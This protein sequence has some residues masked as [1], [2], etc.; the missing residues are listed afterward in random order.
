MA[1]IGE[2]PAEETAR[3]RERSDLPRDRANDY[4]EQAARQRCAFLHHKTGAGFSHVSS[5][6]FEPECVRGNIEH[7]IGAAQVPIGV[8]GPLRI[9][10]EHAQGDF[11]IPLATTE[12][13]VV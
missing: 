11:Y 6:S 13:T 5:Y 12:G 3:S 1:A 7:F 8:A 4:T 9:D 10:G 2:R